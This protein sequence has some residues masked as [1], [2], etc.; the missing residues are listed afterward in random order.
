MDR[1]DFIALGGIAAG[2][3]ALSRIRPADAAPPP[4]T[5]IAPGNQVGVI[6]PNGSTL[7]LRTVGGVKVGHLVASADQLAGER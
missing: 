6:T 4:A 5:I 7:P 3:A 1:R 2:A